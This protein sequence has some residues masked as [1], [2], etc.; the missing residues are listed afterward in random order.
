MLYFANGNHSAGVSAPRFSNQASRTG[1]KSSAF[2]TRLKLLPSTTQFY[3]CAR[4]PPAW[5]IPWPDRFTSIPRPDQERQWATHAWK[6]A[7]WARAARSAAEPGWYKPLLGSRGTRSLV[8]AVVPATPSLQ[9]RRHCRT[10]FP[11]LLCAGPLGTGPWVGEVG[12]S[13]LIEKWNRVVLVSGAAAARE[14][15]ASSCSFKSAGGQT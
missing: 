2:K 10:R 8:G 5:Q 6:T 15:R 3:S 13:L 4:A 14:L 9:A 7:G 11:V 12:R 1:R